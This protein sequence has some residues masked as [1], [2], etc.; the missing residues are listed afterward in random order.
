[1]TPFSLLE[2]RAYSAAL[3]VTAKTAPAAAVSSVGRVGEL[4]NASLGETA[5]AQNKP[6]L[7]AAASAAGTAADLSTVHQGVNAVRTGVNTYQAA[8]TA[9][10]LAAVGQA[11]GTAASQA[12]KNVVAPAAVATYAAQTGRLVA[13]P[14]YRQER[15]QDQVTAANNGVLPSVGKALQN[16]SAAVYTAG[17]EFG[18]MLD[19]QA[20]AAESAANATPEPQRQAVYNTS[21]KLNTERTRLNPGYESLP[22]PNRQAVNVQARKNLGMSTPGYLGKVAQ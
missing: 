7:N 18:S 3:K 8:N 11:T 2:K 19:S 21:Q 1:M 22:Y 4:G 5:D 9:G 6:V 15:Y 14:K 10:R 20:G 12:V 16:P 17:K 13:D